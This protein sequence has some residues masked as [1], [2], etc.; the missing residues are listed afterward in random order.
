MNILK[1]MGVYVFCLF[2]FTWG[3]NSSFKK[4][5]RIH[6]ETFGEYSRAC[7]AIKTQNKLVEEF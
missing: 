6:C 7:E 4:S 1:I 3:L 5:T 2:I